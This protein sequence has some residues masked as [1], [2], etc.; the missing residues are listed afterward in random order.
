M[1]LGETVWLLL[2]VLV[3]LQQSGRSAGRPRMPLLYRGLERHLPYRIDRQRRLA[4]VL[5]IFYVVLLLLLLQ[6]VQILPALQL[7]VYMV[8]GDKTQLTVHHE[9][10]LLLLL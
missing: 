1:V 8:F 3:S 9:E 6:Q 5:L 4:Q 10:Q 7:F 2:P